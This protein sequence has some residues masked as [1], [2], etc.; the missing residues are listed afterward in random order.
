MPK[1]TITPQDVLRSKVI[2]PDW[3]PVEI[4]DL[5]DEP[6]S[7]DGSMNTVVSFEVADGDYAGVPLVRFFN[8]K[9]PGFW[10]EYFRACGAEVTEAGGS[11]DPFATKGMKIQVHV[12]NEMY[13][14][15]MRN[16][17]DGFRPLV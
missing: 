4:K 16:S 12:S 5:K 10:I 8:E 17:V 11:Y 13:K 14:G 2:K 7:T 15:Q 3:Y 6:S 1:V 9:A